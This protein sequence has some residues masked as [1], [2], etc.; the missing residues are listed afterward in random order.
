MGAWGEG[1]LDNDRAADW[2]HE[3]L[4]GTGFCDRV[5]AGLASDD[6][7]EVRAAAWLVQTLGRVYVW[8]IDRLDADRARA[9]AALARLL[10]DEA[11]LGARADRAALEAALRDQLDA[12]PEP[13]PD[14]MDV[15]VDVEPE[16]DVEPEV[17][18]EVEPD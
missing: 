3:L 6:P 11:F 5:A 13:R 14:L 16:G 12:L 10:A 8:P 2:M 9:R 17:E 7:D 18:P 1:P 15:E 4:S